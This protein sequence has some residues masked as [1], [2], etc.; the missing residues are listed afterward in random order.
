[1]KNKTQKSI[2]SALLVFVLVVGCF[3]ALPLMTSAAPAPVPGNPGWKAEYS[4]SS[5]KGTPTPIMWDRGNAA[6]DKIPSNAHSAD[7]P[8]LYFYWDDKQKDD[9]VLLVNESVFDYFQD[10]YTYTLP[11]VDKKKDAS[12]I[13]FAK[14]DPGFVLTAKNSNNYWGYKIAKSTGKVIDTV[15]GEKIYAYAIPKQIQFINPNNGK[16]EKED[17]K[18]INMVFIDGKYKDAEFKIVKNWYNEDGSK[19]MF[20]STAAL[21][22]QNELVSFNNDYK[23]GV[24][25]VKIA[26]YLTAV[27]GVKITV[28]E[29]VD[30]DY[31]EQNGRVSQTITVKNNDGPTQIVT[32]NNQKWAYIIIEKIWLDAY[33]KEIKP[34]DLPEGVKAEFTI[35]G[36]KA[37]LGENRVKDGKHIVSEVLPI[38]GFDLM[39]D[40]NVEV[41]IKAGVT[42]KVTFVNKDPVTP[43]RGHIIEKLVDDPNGIVALAEW[44][45][46]YTVEELCLGIHFDLYTESAYSQKS[47]GNPASPVASVTLDADGFADFSQTNLKVNFVEGYYWIVERLDGFAATVFTQADDIRVYITRSGIVGPLSFDYD[48]L[49]TVVNGYNSPKHTLG[50]G[51]AGLNNGGDLFYI[52]VKNGDVEYASFCAHGGSR[53]FAGE[54]GMG[55]NGYLVVERPEMA[56]LANP[57]MAASYVKI[58][59]ALNWIEDNVGALTVTT[60]SYGLVTTQRVVAQTVIWALLGNINVKSSEFA[61]TNLTDEER[62]FVLGA[63]EAADEGY[64][65]NIVDLVYMVCE[66]HHDFAS[67]QPQLV[68]LYGTTKIV[69]KLVDNPTFDVS[70]TKTKYGGPVADGEFAFELFEI[71]DGEIADAPIGIYKNDG[72]GV[73]TATNLAPGEYVFKEVWKYVLGTGNDDSY[74]LVWKPIYPDVDADGLYFTIA[75]DG[76]VTWAG[77]VGDD[78]PTVDNVFYCK[79]TIFWTADY[80]YGLD[81]EERIQLDDGSWINIFKK[82][83]TYCSGDGALTNLFTVP[84]NCYTGGYTLAV[85]SGGCGVTTVFDVTDAL[86]HNYELSDPWYQYDYDLGAYVRLGDYFKCT[87]CG[88]VISKL[89]CENCSE[90]ESPAYVGECECKPSVEN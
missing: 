57:E 46:E 86:D 6:G 11:N 76:V 80:Y 22:K 51:Y 4:Q 75:V 14:G 70:F 2:I 64:F 34:V 29:A 28:T 66:E 18:N 73:V 23:I 20:V 85:C 50:L 24:N 26:D 45:C 33:G 5:D 15:N 90:S 30:N 9:G 60:G 77:Y 58:L 39:S 63:L 37:F 89:F 38:A 31:F 13:E 59:A 61:S 42:E 83:N 88:T 68:P 32:F 43:M 55:C 41:T 74:A 3:A 40:N 8:G 69:N 67:C 27:K 35:N 52:G 16:N 48:A 12:E 17:L 36:V 44:D 62:A 82:N 78:N 84:A 19:M 53:A 87:H 47:L 10:D 1:M 21:A 7:Y 54:S 49:Y 25:T 65:G 81:T 56:G 72:T 79:H 71:I